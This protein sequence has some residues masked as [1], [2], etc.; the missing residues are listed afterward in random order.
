MLLRILQTVTSVVV[1]AALAV[2][3][4][5]FSAGAQQSSAVTANVTA[6][7]V[8]AT[9]AAWVRADAVLIDTRTLQEQ[10]G[11][12]DERGIV[13]FASV[14][15]G[16]YVLVAAPHPPI[17]CADSGIKQFTV[18]PGES[19]NVRVTVRVDHCRVVE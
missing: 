1:L 14:K 11:I 16:N 4:F 19:L 9:G 12:T 13:R 18:K 6:T 15:P 5:A 2:L 7:V 10:R 8:D 3:S 17:D